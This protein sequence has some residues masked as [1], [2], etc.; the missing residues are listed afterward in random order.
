MVATT[1]HSLTDVVAT[2]M[3]EAMPTIALLCA[4]A[5]IEF[6]VRRKVVFMV[7]KK[8]KTL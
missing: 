2:V 3:V 5:I 8:S 4:V 7:V 6:L 1:S